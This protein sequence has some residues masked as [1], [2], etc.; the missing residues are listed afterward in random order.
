MNKQS[1]TGRIMNQTDRVT[2]SD[3]KFEALR[4]RCKGYPIAM[5][6][7]KMKVSPATVKYYVADAIKRVNRAR[8]GEHRLCRNFK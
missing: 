8:H 6:A 7:A 2:I 4:L 1:N 3:P 5:I